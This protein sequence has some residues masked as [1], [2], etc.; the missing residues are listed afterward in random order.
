MI[1]LLLVIAGLQLALVLGLWAHQVQMQREHTDQMEMF[2][3]LAPVLG[4]TA[5]AFQ[6][7]CQEIE[8]VRSQ[9]QVVVWP[10]QGK[11]GES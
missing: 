9:P 3:A 5:L 10:K 6:A 7:L 4:S 1:G 11:H 8:K 2:R